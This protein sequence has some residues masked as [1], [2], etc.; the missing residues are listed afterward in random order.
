[1]CI[2]HEE[3]DNTGTQ[4]KFLGFPP[5]D[6][7]K[8]GPR[9]VLGQSLFFSWGVT[10]LLLLLLVNLRVGCRREHCQRLMQL[11]VLYHI[12]LNPQFLW[13]TCI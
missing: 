12:H 3:L 7:G 11:R 10:V 8:H 6:L 9:T 1:M 13:N 2:G 4:N 5:R